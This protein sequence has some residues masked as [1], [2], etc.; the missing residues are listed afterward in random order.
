[1]SAPTEDEELRKRMEQL[2]N[3][4]R[5]AEAA[6]EMCQGRH[7]WVYDY[8]SKISSVGDSCRCILCGTRQGRYKCEAEVRQGVGTMTWGADQ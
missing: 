6:A 7:N 2:R 5:L 8:V 1:M 4:A 3:K